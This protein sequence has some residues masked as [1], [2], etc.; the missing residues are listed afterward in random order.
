MASCSD[1]HRNLLRIRRRHCR[2]SQLVNLHAW[3]NEVSARSPPAR[4]GSS[5]KL[6][7]RNIHGEQHPHCNTSQQHRTERHFFILESFITPYQPG[8]PVS[9]A[10]QKPFAKNTQNPRARR[11]KPSKYPPKATKTAEI[12]YPNLEKPWKHH[13]L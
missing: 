2:V 12:P 3:N 7:P 9:S 8:I 1:E 13:R 5:D 11:A 6:L 4:G 10:L